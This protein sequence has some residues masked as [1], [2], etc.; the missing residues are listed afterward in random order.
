[1]EVKVEVEARKAAEKPSSAVRAPADTADEGAR[2]F[3]QIDSS[4]RPCATEARRPTAQMMEASSASSS[5]ATRSGSRCAR[6]T[7]GSV[8][9]A[10]EERDKGRKEAKEGLDGGCEEGERACAR[11]DSSPELKANA[12][13]GSAESESRRR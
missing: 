13:S 4:A 5:S 6:S 7:N 1:M 9:L 3:S 10:Y 11:Y 8:V 12:P 2:L